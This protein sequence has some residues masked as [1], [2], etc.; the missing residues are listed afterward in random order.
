VRVKGGT[1]DQKTIFYTAMYHAMFDPREFSDVDGRYYGGDYRV[2]QREDFTYRTIFSGWDAFRSHIPLL[3]IIDPHTVGQLVN[4]LI[5]KARLGGRGL[6]KWEIAGCY[7]GCMLGDPAIP[8]IL[9]AY[10]KGIRNFDVEA[11]YAYSRQTSLGPNTTRNGWEDYNKLGYVACNPVPARWKGYYKG[12]SATLENCYADWC[13]SQLAKD[14]GKEEDALLFEDRAQ[15]YRNIYDDSTGYMRGRYRSGD[16]IPWEG[17]LGFQQGCI[18]SNP[19]QQ[20]WF[21]PHDVDGFQK[22][23]GR[24]RFLR[25]L[26]MLFDNTPK[27]FE[28]N[29]YYNHANEPVHHIPYMFY[30]TKKPWLTQ[31]W[32]RTI[33]NNAYG[34]SPYGIRGNEDVGQMSAW[35]ILSAIGFHPVCPG[36]NRYYFGSPLF[37]EVEIPLDKRYYAGSAFRV[38]TV[39]NGP[40]KCYIQKATLNGQMLDRPYVTHQEIIQGGELVFEMGAEPN[41]EYFKNVKL[42]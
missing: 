22:L 7:S 33:L 9:D 36:D 14:L 2:H 35:Y 1:E 15:Y 16:W 5:D 6:P 11:A 10:R 29:D 26:E 23:F 18:E 21:V 24:E 39:N 12:V 41:A 38:K 3:T 13:I 32:V 30:F 31:R 42:P 20:S 28:F 40:D 34:T 37:D 4:S 27:N 17:R 8:V 19:L 25:E